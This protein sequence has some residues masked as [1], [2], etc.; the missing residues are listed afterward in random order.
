MTT[1]VVTTQ[2]AMLRPKCHKM[3]NSLVW[4]G[5]GI[6]L[7]ASGVFHG[8]KALDQG[9]H[10]NLGPQEY[11]I[12]GKYYTDSGN[13][14]GLP[15]QVTK[16]HEVLINWEDFS[17][18]FVEPHFWRTLAKRLLEL[19]QPVLV[20]CHGGH[21][22]TGT[23]LAILLGLWGVKQPMSFVRQNYCVEAGESVAQITYLDHVLTK[24]GLA[25]QVSKKTYE[26]TDWTAPSYAAAAY[27]SN[28]D[29][30]GWGATVDKPVSYMATP[31]VKTA[32]TKAQEV[33]DALAANEAEEIWWEER[34]GREYVECPDGVWRRRDE[35]TQ[36]EIEA[37][38]WQ[39]DYK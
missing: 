24:C 4:S 30:G 36:A 9:V 17:I 10:I 11:G 21:G 15:K 29:L 25:G 33:A 3:G 32:Q 38:Q 16:Q 7:W 23:A 13:I 6:H 26:E 20:F 12:L 31:T 14:L 18:P 8:M 19:K 22:R 35:M 1:A 34:Y 39:G 37:T 28:D 27:W 2:G 5:K